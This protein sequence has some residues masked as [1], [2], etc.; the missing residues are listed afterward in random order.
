MTDAADTKADEVFAAFVARD[1]RT[2]STLTALIAE[3]LRDY[4]AEQTAGL[5]ALVGRQREWME[6]AARVLAEQSET[7]LLDAAEVILAD[8]EDQG[9][10]GACQYPACATWG[11]RCG[12]E[13][14]AAVERARLAD[15]EG[16]R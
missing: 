6:Q 2:Q 14:A 3:A 4:A 15:P 13:M 16:Q 7:G 12:A 9:G 1:R 10:G 8:P 11:C 5:R